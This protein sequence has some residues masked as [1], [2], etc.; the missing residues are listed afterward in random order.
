MANF[1]LDLEFEVKQQWHILSSD[2]GYIYWN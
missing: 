1:G 2:M